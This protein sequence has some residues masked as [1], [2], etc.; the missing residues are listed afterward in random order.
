MMPSQKS[1][2]PSLQ[3][4]TNAYEQNCPV[5]L[6]SKPPYWKSKS[7]TYEGNELTFVSDTSAQKDVYTGPM[8]MEEQLKAQLAAPNAEQHA[9]SDVQALILEQQE[10]IRD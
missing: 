1:R 2:W 4:Q 3:G 8:D 5:Q 10:A 7:R 9:A 6:S